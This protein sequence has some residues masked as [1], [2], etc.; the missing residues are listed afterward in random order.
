MTTTVLLEGHQKNNQRAK[1]LSEV[2]LIGVALVKSASSSDVCTCAGS[3][4]KLHCHW[5]SVLAGMLTLILLFCCRVEDVVIDL[6]LYI[7]RTKSATR[8]LKAIAVQVKDDL[9]FI[10]KV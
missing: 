1:L 9:T 3:P 2:P 5:C 8:N 10:D 7:D 4:A 6:W